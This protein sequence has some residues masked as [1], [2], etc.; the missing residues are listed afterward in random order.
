VSQSE[1]DSR[2]VIEVLLV[3]RVSGLSKYATPPMTEAKK[4]NAMAKRAIR[5]Q[6][7]FP[8]QR[9]VEQPV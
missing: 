3:T 7:F 1:W 6:S 8:V 9:R 5:Q 4:I 2:G